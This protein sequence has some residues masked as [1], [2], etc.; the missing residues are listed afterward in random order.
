MDRT[1]SG[2]R[3]TCCAHFRELHNKLSRLKNRQG[4]L[5]NN[6]SAS[7]RISHDFAMSLMQLVGMK[8]TLPARYMGQLAGQ[9]LVRLRTTCLP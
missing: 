9:S 8:K 1:V 6:V 7:L 4:D 2:E 3:E 5:S